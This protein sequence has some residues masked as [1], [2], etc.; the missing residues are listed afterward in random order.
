MSFVPDAGDRTF[1]LLGHFR[2]ASPALGHAA[3]VSAILEIDR[4]TGH[5]ATFFGVST[6]FSHQVHGR[7]PPMEATMEPMSCSR[8]AANFL[9]GV[10][11]AVLCGSS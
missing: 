3:P 7:I 2:A 5:P 8:H 10:Q 4:R 1:L 9:K 6:K 11:A